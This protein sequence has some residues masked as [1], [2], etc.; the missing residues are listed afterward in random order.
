M[1]SGDGCKGN[2]GGW[3]T[4]DS[5]EIVGSDVGGYEVDVEVTDFSEGVREA[6]D[7]SKINVV[8]AYLSACEFESSEFQSAYFC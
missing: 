7:N 1:M 4:C 8:G 5:V 2:A 3:D 6:W